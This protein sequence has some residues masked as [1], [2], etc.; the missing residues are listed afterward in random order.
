MATSRG[1]GPGQEAPQQADAL[2]H[3]SMKR[4]P[5]M[6]ITGSQKGQHKVVKSASHSTLKSRMPS[7]V[8]HRNTQN[9][10][11]LLLLLVLL[12]NGPLLRTDIGHLSSKGEH[13]TRLGTGINHLLCGVLITRLRVAR[14]GADIRDLPLQGVHITRLKVTRLGTDIQDLL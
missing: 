8:I 6:M 11:S 14:L 3:E 13:I 9:L 1:T 10:C 4:S 12:L 2:A 7:M 5:A